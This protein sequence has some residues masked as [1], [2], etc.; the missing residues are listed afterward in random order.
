[1]E[2]KDE[3]EKQKGRAAEIETASRVSALLRNYTSRAAA[4]NRLPK[5]DPTPVLQGLF[6]EV[7]SV[8]A[9]AKKSRREGESYTRTER[10]RNAVVEELGD[11]LWYF[12]ALCGHLGHA[13]A[14][15]FSS[16]I[17]GGD[18]DEIMVESEGTASHDAGSADVSDIDELLLSLGEAS[19]ALLSVR[20]KDGKDEKALSL[21]RT[22]ADCYLRVVQAKKVAFAEIVQKNLDKSRGRFIKPDYSTLP[23]FDG[24][25]DEDEKLP[26]KFEIEIV[27]RAKGKSHMRWNGVF[28]GDPLT[29]NIIDKDGYR[30]HD[31]FHL[32]Y[33]AIL[34]WSPIFRGLIKHKR[35]SRS[36]IDE[37][38]DGG[39]ARVVEEGVSAWIFSQAKDL[40]F[41]QNQDRVS[42]DLLKGVQNFVKGY[43]VEKC[44][45]WLWEYAILEGFKVFM[46][47]WDNEGGVVIGDRVKRTISYEESLP[48]S[49]P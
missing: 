41:F 25:F 4:T 5:D 13:A 26:E 49:E 29:D 32:S 31:V 38:E 2:K 9:T 40:D 43:E 18:F 30:F 8:M 14:E 17:G 47:V 16:V 21:L 11:T 15:I 22:F 46:R 35:K 39:R 37:A 20:K 7:G 44:P 27:E 48:G 28:I 1:M 23:T 19:S 3:T 45:L 24:G 33:A 12:N 42:F 36:E 34:H 6:G 10:H